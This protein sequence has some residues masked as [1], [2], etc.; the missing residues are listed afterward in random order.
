MSSESKEQHMADLVTDM[1]HD[2]MVR[3]GES[4]YAAGAAAEREA[5]IEMAN[6]LYFWDDSERLIKAIRARGQ[7]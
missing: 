4:A 2:A 6:D 3:F 7:A 5:I 1:V